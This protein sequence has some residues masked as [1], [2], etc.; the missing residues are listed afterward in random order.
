MT[1]LWNHTRTRR[2]SVAQV[3]AVVAGE[4]RRRAARAAK[5]KLRCIS[6]FKTQ[7]VGEYLCWF[8]AEGR[9]DYYGEVSVGRAHG[10]G[11]AEYQDG[12]WCTR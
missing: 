8:S 1:L 3:A 6:E 4:E 5:M 7:G 12:S 9:V 11:L 10:W 2:R